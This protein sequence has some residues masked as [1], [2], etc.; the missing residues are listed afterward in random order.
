[1]GRHAADRPRKPPLHADLFVPTPG[2]AAARAARERANSAFDT[3]VEPHR[4]R[5][6]LSRCPLPDPASS[7]VRSWW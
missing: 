5:S 2:S 3:L 4:G 6:R 7:P 1:M